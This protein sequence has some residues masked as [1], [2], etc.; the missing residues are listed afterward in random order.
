MNSIDQLRPFT[1]TIPTTDGKTDAL[2]DKLLEQGWVVKDGKDGFE[3][4]AK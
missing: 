1:V 3:L 2:R 4:E